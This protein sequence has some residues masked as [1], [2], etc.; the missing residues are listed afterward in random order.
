M[1]GLLISKLESKWAIVTMFERKCGFGVK[2]KVAH[3]TSDLVNRAIVE[4]F[5]PFVDRV[6]KLTYDNGQEFAAHIQIDQAIKS[7][8]YFARPFA[9]WERGSNENFNGLLSQFVPKKRSMN[10]VD[11]DEITMIQNTFRGVS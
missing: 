10:T 2:V 5:Q 7:T 1:I 6:K 3:K 8:G 9:S 11:E 4:G